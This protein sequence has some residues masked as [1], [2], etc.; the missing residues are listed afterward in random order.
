MFKL[1]LILFTSI[2]FAALAKAECNSKALDD[3]KLIR[4]YGN[5][6]THR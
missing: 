3:F 2:L 4:S 5:E 6:K 1:I